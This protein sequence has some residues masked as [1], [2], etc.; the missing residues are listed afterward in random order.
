M[1]VHTSYQNPRGAKRLSELTG[2]PVVQLPYTVGGTE[3]V[4]DLFSLF[5]VTL[6][7]LMGNAQ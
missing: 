5:D 2:V 3:Q 7:K 6:Q 1:I 4:T